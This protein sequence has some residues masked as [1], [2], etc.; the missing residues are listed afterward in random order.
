VSA[1][2]GALA[3]LEVTIAG[4]GC[5]LAGLEPVRVHRQAHAATGLSPLSARLEKDAVKPLGLGETLTLEYVTSFKYTRVPAGELSGDLCQ[6]RRAVRRRMENVDI[7]VEFDPGMVPR[8]VWWAVWDGVAGNV[9]SQE[10]VA[11]DGQNSAQRFLRF[12]ENT[13]AGF[14]WQW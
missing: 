10:S 13:V 4:A 8:H 14:H 1:S 3:T 2:P 5:A 11:L 12:I 7:R 9:I 6:Y